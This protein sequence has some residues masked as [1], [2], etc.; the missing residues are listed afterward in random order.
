MARDDE[1]GKVEA[2]NVTKQFDIED[3]DQGLAIKDV[4]FTVQPN[5]FLTIVEWGFVSST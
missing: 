2:R 3:S 5:E 4:N 1:R